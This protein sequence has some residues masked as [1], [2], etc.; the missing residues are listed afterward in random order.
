MTLPLLHGWPK[1]SGS[2]AVVFGAPSPCPPMPK[3]PPRR[4]GSWCSGYSN[5]PRHPIKRLSPNGLE[6]IGSPAQDQSKE[7]C[8][9]ARLCWPSVVQKLL[10]ESCSKMAGF[11]K[12]EVSCVMLSP[13]AIERNKRRMILPE[14]VLGKL[15]PKRMSL[16][17]AMGPISLPTWSLSCL[18][19]ARASSHGVWGV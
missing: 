15:S 16:G 14:R 13:L 19:M 1:K 18:A 6:K 10:S 17:L 12:V 11:S 7:V 5:C 9:S 4:R 3:S 2:V 8:L